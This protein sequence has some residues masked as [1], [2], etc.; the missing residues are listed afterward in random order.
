MTVSRLSWLGERV[1]VAVA[2][3][4]HRTQTLLRAYLNG[5]GRSCFE[6]ADTDDAQC[7]IADYDHPAARHELQR[8]RARYQR[9]AI[10]L[11]Q[12]NPSLPGTVWVPKPVDLDALDLAA[13]RV[14][15]LLQAAVVEPSSR[16]FASGAAGAGERSSLTLVSRPPG[17]VRERAGPYRMGVTSDWTAKIGWMALGVLAITAFAAALGWRPAVDGWRAPTRSLQAADSVATAGPQALRRAVSAAL[18]EPYRLQVAERERLNGLLEETQWAPAFTRNGPDWL[19]LGMSPDGLLVSAH[20]LPAAL[21]AQGAPLPVRV[22]REQALKA[23]VAA[24]LA[25]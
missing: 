6:T 2:C 21:M 3:D 1:R 8:F 9:P 23:A 10:V 24:A 4:G 7:L 17:P 16:A 5:S 13:H 14:R 25:P 20:A 15:T 18:Q 11:A 12:R 19:A 22:E